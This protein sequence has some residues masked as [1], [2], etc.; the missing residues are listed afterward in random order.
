MNR[1]SDDYIGPFNTS[2]AHPS[3]SPPAKLSFL[4]VSN[5][6]PCGGAFTS[7]VPSFSH[8]STFLSVLLNPRKPR[9]TITVLQVRL[10]GGPT[11]HVVLG[12]MYRALR[13]RRNRRP[14]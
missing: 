7:S 3:S 4:P 5:T 14:L 10:N 13:R 8:Q 9:S 1:S 12:V 6:N 2:L 11:S